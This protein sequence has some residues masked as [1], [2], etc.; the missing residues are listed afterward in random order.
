MKRII[1]FLCFSSFRLIMDLE[2]GERPPK[3]AKPADGE[4]VTKD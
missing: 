3:E 2:G 4:S 1:L